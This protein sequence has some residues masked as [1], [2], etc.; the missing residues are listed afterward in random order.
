MNSRNPKTL[1]D[2]LYAFGIYGEIEIVENF[3]SKGD[4]VF[5]VGANIGAWSKVVLDKINN[6]KIHMFE[7]A[8]HFCKK[9]ASNFN[10]SIKAG[11]VVVNQAAVLDVV[12]TK[13]FY[14]YSRLADLSTLYPRNEQIMKRFRIGVP[15][16]LKV[17][18]ITLDNYCKEKGIKHVDFLKVDVEGSEFDVLKG[19]SRL[20]S[21]KRIDV[22][23]FEYGGCFQD[24]RITLQDVFRYVLSKK[25][26]IFKPST[27]GMIHIKQF[28]PSLED[29]KLSN[30]L[31]VKRGF[32]K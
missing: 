25:Y 26:D 17:H 12:T 9:L 10:E 13:D 7:A 2:H 31:V 30:Y 18:T 8:P 4:I 19:A 24:A 3:I 32:K 29:Y 15:K 28:Y 14:L 22:V 1:K 5:D 6:V 20:L 27:N 11:R 21:E 23:Q 16:I